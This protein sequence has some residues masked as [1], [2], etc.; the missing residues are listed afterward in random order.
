MNLS[1]YIKKYRHSF[2]KEFNVVKH[3]EILTRSATKETESKNK[4]SRSKEFVSYS[5]PDNRVIT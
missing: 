3:Q 5:L 1:D 2:N 4:L